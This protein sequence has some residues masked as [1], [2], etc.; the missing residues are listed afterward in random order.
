MKEY[1]ECGFCSLGETVVARRGLTLQDL[2]SASAD[3]SPEI[4]PEKL[5]DIF[6]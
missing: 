1:G 3:G 4:S 6:V 2:H 5:L